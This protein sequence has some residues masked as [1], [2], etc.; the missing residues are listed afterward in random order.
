[1]WYTCDEREDV[2]TEYEELT[3]PEPYRAHLMMEPN[4]D[5]RGNE[6]LDRGLRGRIAKLTAQARM[7][8]QR[9]R[10]VAR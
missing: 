7:N 8:L 9:C 4:E 3:H 5:G 2:K 6:S 1:M 10:N